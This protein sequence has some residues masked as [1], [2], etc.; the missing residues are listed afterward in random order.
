MSEPGPDLATISRRSVLRAA[1]VAAGIAVIG[2]ACSSADSTQ[3]ADPLRSLGHDLAAGPDGAQL[4]QAAADL[5]T[6]TTGLNDD[7]AV[8]AA[9]AHLDAHSRGD[10]AAGRTVIG[11][12]WVLSR[13]EAATLVA[14]AESNP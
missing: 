11:R 5:G 8:I 14:Y 6:M 3:D 1:L 9:L 10:F 13:T 2:P 12:G 7:A 4:R